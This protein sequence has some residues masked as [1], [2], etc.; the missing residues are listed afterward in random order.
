VGIK[1]TVIFVCLN[2]VTSY[3]VLTGSKFNIVGMSAAGRS[4]IGNLG[5]FNSKVNNK[6]AGVKTLQT[7]KCSKVSFTP[8]ILLKV[9]RKLKPKPSKGPDEYSPKLLKHIASCIYLYH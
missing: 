5:Q 9:L 2:C 1:N 6:S 3:P 4:E 8:G 7:T